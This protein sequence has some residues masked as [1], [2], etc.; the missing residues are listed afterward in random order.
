MAVSERQLSGKKT[1]ETECK[2][3]FTPITITVKY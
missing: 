3:L 2:G 1:P